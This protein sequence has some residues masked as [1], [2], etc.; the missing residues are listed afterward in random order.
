MEPGRGIP[1]IASAGASPAN[2]G[3][4]PWNTPSPRTASTT[5]AAR[6]LPYYPPALVDPAHLRP[7][8]LMLLEILLERPTHKALGFGRHVGKG[9][10]IK[11]D[12]VLP[13]V[14]A[15]LRRYGFL[16]SKDKFAREALRIAKEE[17]VQAQHPICSGPPGWWFAATYAEANEAAGLYDSIENDAKRKAAAIRAG[18][19]AVYGLG[20][21]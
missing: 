17:L 13:L 1:P 4:R 12:D 9:R 18:A 16:D 6:S 7:A 5:A 21:L 8:A 20:M 3:S 10:A 14:E 19:E 11:I 2:V 15:R